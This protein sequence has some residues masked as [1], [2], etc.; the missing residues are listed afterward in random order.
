MAVIYKKSEIKYKGKV[1]QRT[2]IDYWTDIY[3][4]KEDKIPITTKDITDYL[5]NEAKEDYGCD[6]VRTEAGIGVD[7]YSGGM[8][9]TRADIVRFEKNGEIIGIEVKSDKDILDR[10]KDQVKVYSAFFDNNYLAV[11]MKHL[12]EARKSIPNYWG[13]ILLRKNKSG[14]IFKYVLRAP[15]LKFKRKRLARKED[16]LLSM[17]QMELQ[18]LC[19]Y[20]DL[21]RKGISYKDGC[22]A[23]LMEAMTTGE[24]IEAWKRSFRRKKIN[25]KLNAN[26][27]EVFGG[28]YEEIDDFRREEV[29]KKRMAK[30]NRKLKKIQAKNPPCKCDCEYCIKK[31]C[32]DCDKRVGDEWSKLIPCQNYKEYWRK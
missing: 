29:R 20:Y 25:N 15:E 11:G 28:L 24:V 10:L 5:V 21:D 4:D 19:L 13:L 8:G 27:R 23:K 2:E 32:Y 26:K 16:F 17:W 22:V 12:E 3:E 18:D 14:E 1:Y 6:Y 7:E 9:K 31:K 30:A